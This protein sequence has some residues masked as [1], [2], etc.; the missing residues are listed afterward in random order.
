MS[1]H[2]KES[3]PLDL[4]AIRARVE[5]AT[6]APWTAHDDGLVW[7]DR[8]GDPVSGSEQL[9]DAEFIAAARSDIPALLAA[10][11]EAQRERDD[12]RLAYTPWKV[13]L[14]AERDA[15]RA[16]AE[17]MREQYDEA[18]QV[19]ASVRESLELVGQNFDEADARAEQ[20]AAEVVRLRALADDPTTNP[21]WRLRSER[22]EATI[23][24]VRALAAEWKQATG[25]RVSEVVGAE[26]LATLDGPTD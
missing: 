3:S 20:A 4:Q 18:C 13:A 21:Y 15:A 14:V 26:L 16:D 22:A 5:A 1:D 23:E 12:W 2:A 25:W 24:R 9:A 7:P 10:L 19:L 8:M 6:P 17:R 11:D